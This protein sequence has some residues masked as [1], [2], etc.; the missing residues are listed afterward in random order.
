MKTSSSRIVTD[1]VGPLMLKTHSPGA[2]ADTHSALILYGLLL[3]TQY[4]LR[5]SDLR[6][7]TIMWLLRTTYYSGWGLFIYY[8]NTIIIFKRVV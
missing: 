1:V 4:R 7:S 6:L 5:D 2:G 3:I 8:H